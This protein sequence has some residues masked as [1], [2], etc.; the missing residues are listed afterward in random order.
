[1][2][3]SVYTAIPREGHRRHAG[4]LTVSNLLPIFSPTSSAEREKYATYAAKMPWTIIIPVSSGR[5]HRMRLYCV[6][7]RKLYVLTIARVGRKR[8][9][10]FLFLSCILLVVLVV[11]FRGERPTLVFRRE[12]LQ[13]IWYWEVSS[14]H[15][16]SRQGSEYWKYLPLFISHTRFST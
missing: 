6:N 12:D 4:R 11:F 9:L 15:F 1:M 8:G 2:T 13:R 10:L 3:T 14:G 16:P 7:P 5:T